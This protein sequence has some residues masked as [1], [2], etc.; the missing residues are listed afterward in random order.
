MKSKDIVD[1]GRK[2]KGYFTFWLYGHIAE[3]NWVSRARDEDNGRDNLHPIRGARCN[4]H[5]VE[6]Q[7]RGVG[8]DTR[9][10]PKAQV[11]CVKICPAKEKP[12]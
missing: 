3:K 12:V 8:C 6:S 9:Q 1:M 10:S 5:C 7:E 2:V 4:S 11:R